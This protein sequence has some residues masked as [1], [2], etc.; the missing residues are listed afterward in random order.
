MQILAIIYK[1]RLLIRWYAA[2]PATY[3]TIFY[4]AKIYLRF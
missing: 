2:T 4:T 3:R 1:S